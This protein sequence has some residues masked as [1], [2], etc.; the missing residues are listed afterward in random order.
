MKEVVAFI[1]QRKGADN[2]SVDD[3]VYGPAA[4]LG[5][6]TS[7]EM[8]R[9]LELAAHE[10]YVDVKDDKV[11]AIF[12]HQDVNI[13]LGFRPTGSILEEVRER[14]LFQRLL[15]EIMAIGKR[16]KQDVLALANEKQD[17][18][19]LEIE[20]ALLLVARELELELP[21]MDLFLDEA[22]AK[23]LGKK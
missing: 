10:G 18:M 15:E 4:D 7:K 8:R 12:D 17:S 23:L 2:L 14:P 6:F 3:F 5:W 22:E 9:L 1:F 21:S 16:K 11:R 13:P 20:V 19:N